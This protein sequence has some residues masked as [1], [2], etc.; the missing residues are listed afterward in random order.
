MRD[1][2]FAKDE[3]YHVYNRGNNKREVF[4]DG[5]DLDRFLLSIQYFN[6][7]ELTGSIYLQSFN[8]NQN[9]LSSL[10]TKLVDVIGYC[11]NPNHF[12]LI[13]SQR[14][15][16]GISKF[17]HRLG[18]GY[19]RF[20]NEK[21]KSSGSLF[22]GTYKAKH[23]N[24]NEYLLHLSAYVNLNQDAHDILTKDLSRSSWAEYLSNKNG[25]C[26]KE[27]ILSQFTNFNKYK[28]FAEDSLITIKK[29]KELA[30]LLEFT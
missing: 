22:Q 30:Y 15:E 9:Q 19:T 25:L 29:N 4:K 11:L 20:F 1:L 12:H 17:M 27:I 13:L 7:L 16:N 2:E 5:F 28:K 6:N 14:E 3:Y 24:S 26:N 21:Y 10:V 23:V 18:T 8:Q